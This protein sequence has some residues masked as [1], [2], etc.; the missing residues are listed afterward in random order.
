MVKWFCQAKSVDK[1]CNSK[2][3]FKILAVGDRMSPLRGL[4]I[5]LDKRG[6]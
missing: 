6:D 1:V 5:E 2:R 3:K 4:L